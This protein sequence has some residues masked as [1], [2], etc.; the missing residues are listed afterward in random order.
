M[1]IMCLCHLDKENLTNTYFQSV[2]DHKDIIRSSMSL[3]GLILILRD[4]VSKV[5]NV[6]IKIIIHNLV[7]IR[8]YNNIV[9]MW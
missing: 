7:Y 9:Y 8:I 1:F 4:D 6:R 3:Q 2:S 5:G